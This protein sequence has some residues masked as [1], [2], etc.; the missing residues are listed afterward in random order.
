MNKNVNILKIN[1]NA[2][3]KKTN[4]TQ[5]GYSYRREKSNLERRLLPWKYNA[6]MRTIRPHLISRCRCMRNL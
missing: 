2:F 5:K 1:L 6:S 3:K 4:L